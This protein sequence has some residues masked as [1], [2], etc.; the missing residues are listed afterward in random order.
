[1]ISKLDQSTSKRL[2]KMFPQYKG[3]GKCSCD[4]LISV[5]TVKFSVHVT[6]ALYKTQLGHILVLTNVSYVNKGDF[7]CSS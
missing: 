5:N 4:G 2:L 1:M 7:S 6:H 3:K